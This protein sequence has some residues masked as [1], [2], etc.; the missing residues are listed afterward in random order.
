MLVCSKHLLVLDKVVCSK[1]RT[2]T[3]PISRTLSSMKPLKK[4]GKS[5]SRGI[6]FLTVTCPSVIDNEIHDI[7]EPTRM[8]QSLLSLVSS[9]S[10]ATNTKPAG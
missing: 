4:I 6:H 8:E 9:A 10:A 7:L 1:S 3:K 5:V 2:N